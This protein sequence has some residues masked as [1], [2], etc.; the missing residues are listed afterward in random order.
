MD[1]K[2][3]QQNNFGLEALP[4]L[5]H[6]QTEQ[7]MKYLEKD[8]DKFLK[9]WWNHVGDR[10]PE[11]K[12]ITYGGTAFETEKIDSKTTLVIITLPSPK[13]DGDPYFLAFVA[14]PERRFFLVR[15]PTTIAFALVRDDKCGQEHLTRFGFLTPMGI[16]RSRGVGLNPT[17]TDFKRIVKSK[18]EK[19]KRN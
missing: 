19:R 15:I 11:N 5:F 17:K 6:S 18:I 1:I 10:M 7:F 8:G 9:F 3:S 13:E 14:K 4:I 12:R 2:K 16:F